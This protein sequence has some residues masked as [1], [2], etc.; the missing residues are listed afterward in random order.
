M[1]KVCEDS[2]CVSGGALGHTF[3]MFNEQLGFVGL[4]TFKTP[5]FDCVSKWKLIAVANFSFVGV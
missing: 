5:V 2:E 1:K 3:I 4:L